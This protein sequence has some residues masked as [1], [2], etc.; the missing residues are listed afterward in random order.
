MIGSRLSAGALAVAIGGCASSEWVGD[1]R[2]L[3][4]GLNR[5]EDRTLGVAAAASSAGPSDGRLEGPIDA[6]AVV[7]AARAGN[8]EVR[9]AVARA[10]AA[11]EEID[12][13]GALDD[14]KLKV[15]AENVPWSHAGSFRRDED[16]KFGVMQDFPFPGK[17][18]LRSETA[19]REAEAAYQ[20]ARERERDVVLRIRK[21]Y[22]D[23]YAASREMEIL[24]EHVALLEE[25]EKAADARYRAGTAPQQDVLRTQVELVKLHND[26]L[27][28]SQRIDS[29]RAAL[30][31]L[32]NRPVQAP[33][34]PPGEIVPREE[35]FD[36]DA[37]LAR[38]KAERPELRA[39]DLKVRASLVGLTLAERDASLPDFFV[40]ADY[41]Q[42][43]GMEDG[44][45]AMVGIN[46][47]WFTGKHAA[48][49]RKMK[50]TLRADEFGAAAAKN[51]VAFEVRDAARRVEAVR[52]SLTLFR[53]EL[54]AK[55]AQG[56]EVSRAAYAVGQATLL[57]VLDA[58]RSLR[59]VNLDYHRALAAYESAV[60]DLE[61]AVGADLRGNP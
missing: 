41:M 14:P 12:R 39:A 42:S 4:E 8:P 17:L 10:R 57:D 50:Q 32:L 25:M 11:R 38:A 18:S 16:N 55:S 60:A 58:E 3:D 44:W 53:G 30:N 13:V 31:A 37:L 52:K 40:G 27:F 22:Y 47:P 15:E 2:R 28:V 20:E 35:T 9:E 26:V 49:V 29:A 59:D 46:L 54:L 19:L 56:V 43:P 5:F 24:R 45:G 6:D 36:A 23:Y 48:E 51:R 34:G 21:G 61:R 33:L 1:Y 7:E